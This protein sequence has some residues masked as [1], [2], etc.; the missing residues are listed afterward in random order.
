MTMMSD[1]YYDYASSSSDT[2]SSSYNWQP[3]YRTRVDEIKERI[4][5]INKQV[6]ELRTKEGIITDVKIVKT[7]KEEVENIAEPQYFDPKDLVL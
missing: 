7:V 2:S 4:K 6:D 3:T 1:Y 5:N